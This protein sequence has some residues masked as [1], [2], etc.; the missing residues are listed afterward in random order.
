MGP[1]A[2]GPS[3]CPVPTEDSNE[4]PILGAY[5]L[6]KSMVVHLLMGNAAKAETA[7]QDLLTAHP[8]ETPGYKITEMA[9]SFWNEYKSTQDIAKACAQSI[10]YIRTQEN[11]LATLTGGY[12]GFVDQGI[13]YEGN[14]G[15]ACPFK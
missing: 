5:A 9:T 13:W 6:F 12:N 4:R 11:V 14:P 2:E 8:S 1:C 10:S 7:Y 15:E 3:I